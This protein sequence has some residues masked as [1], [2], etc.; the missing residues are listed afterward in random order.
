M[1]ELQFSEQVLRD[2][3][4]SELAAHK[5]VCRIPITDEHAKQAAVLIT[6]IASMGGGNLMQ[7]FRDT[8]ENH[9]WLKKQ[10]QRG[11]KLSTAFCYTMVAGVAS[12]VMVALWKGI[13][14]L[15]RET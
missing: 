3:I 8:Q 13:K 6:E 4:R 1:S 9:A 7:G 12:G 2:V 11:E 15:I 14:L 5:H 10:R